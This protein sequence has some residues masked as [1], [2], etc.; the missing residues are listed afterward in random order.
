MKM[1]YQQPLAEVFAVLL[2]GL[3]CLSGGE[4][5]NPGEPGSVFNPGNIYDGG[6]M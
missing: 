2:E 3:V 5:G 1:T 6:M 4:L